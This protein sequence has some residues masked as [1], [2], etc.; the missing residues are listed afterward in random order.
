MES[1]A[2]MRE[3]VTPLQNIQLLTWCEELGIHVTWNILI[4]IPGAPAASYARMAELARVLHHLMPPAGV[5]PFQLHRFSP[6][7]EHRFTVPAA[8]C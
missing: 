8:G 6:F 5:A 1:L 4:G 3:G 7:F 2:L